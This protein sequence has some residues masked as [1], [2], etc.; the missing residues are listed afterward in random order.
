MDKIDIEGEIGMGEIVRKRGYWDFESFEGG[1]DGA[2][3]YV[4]K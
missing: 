4:S 3:M 1:W 2:S